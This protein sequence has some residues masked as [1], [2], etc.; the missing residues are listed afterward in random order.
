MYLEHLE[1]KIIIIINFKRSNNHSASILS[2]KSVHII[3]Q[4]IGT[5]NQAKSADRIWW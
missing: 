2:I 5:K 1:Y 4:Q 3:R